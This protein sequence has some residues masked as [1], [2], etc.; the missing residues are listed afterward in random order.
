MVTLS[1]P[2]YHYCLKA[3]SFTKGYQEKRLELT[4]DFCNTLSRYAC[5]YKVEELVSERINMVL[6]ITLMDCV[7]QEI[8]RSRETGVRKTYRMIKEIC[9]HSYVKEV[10]RNMNTDGFHMKQKLFLVCDQAPIDSYGYDIGNSSGK[11]GN[12][13]VIVYGYKNY[14]EKN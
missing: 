4:I 11:T 5:D 7:K 2:F 12:M 1:H 14:S 13:K 9:N 10:I 8:L 3:D 6:W